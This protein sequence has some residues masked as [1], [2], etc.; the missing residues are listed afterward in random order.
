MGSEM[1]IRDRLQLA[2][3]PAKQFD[4]VSLFQQADLAADGLR[5]QVQLVAGADDAAGLGHN[6]EIMQLAVVE[7]GHIQFV[8]SEV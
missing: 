2:A 4:A 1:C 6:P 8:K 5:G 7:H 3:N